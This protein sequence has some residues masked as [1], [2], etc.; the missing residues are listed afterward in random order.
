MKYEDVKYRIQV[1]RDNLFDDL[2][3]ER[4]IVMEHN[5]Y[6][7]EWE[8]ALRKYDELAIRYDQMNKV[9]ELFT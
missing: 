1:M 9:W 8:R 2:Q 5:I 3:V 7:Q 6:G 4:K